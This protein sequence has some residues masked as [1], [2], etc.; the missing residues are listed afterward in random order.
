MR[1]YEQGLKSVYNGFYSVPG[2]APVVPAPG[3]LVIAADERITFA[4]YSDLNSSRVDSEW[5]AARG[6]HVRLIVPVDKL[7]QRQ[8]GWHLAIAA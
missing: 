2:C 4:G 5:G 6:H 1:D 8:I 7:Y 3:G